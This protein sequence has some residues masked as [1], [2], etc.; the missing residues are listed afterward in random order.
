M[1]KKVIVMILAVLMIC[2]PCMTSVSAETGQ[3]SARLTTSVPSDHKVTVITHG[4]K[5]E[6]DGRVLSKT[7]Y[8][9][10]QSVQKYS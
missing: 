3:N 6:A 5:V 10:R 4:G 2:I 8:F 9:S 7:E 1:I